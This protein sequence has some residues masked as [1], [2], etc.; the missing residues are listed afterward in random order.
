[1]LIIGGSRSGRT[2]SL[3]NL[4]N[5][6][7]YIDKIY[8]YAKDPNEVKYTFSINKMILKPLFNTQMI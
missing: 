4:I 6:E 1:M 3:F 5:E 2:N 7:P 8:L